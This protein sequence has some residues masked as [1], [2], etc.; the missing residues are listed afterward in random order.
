[1]NTLARL[2]L[3][4][5][6]SVFI[7]TVRGTKIAYNLSRSEVPGIYRH[8]NFFCGKYLKELIWILEKKIDLIISFKFIVLCT[9]K[10]TAYS[11]S[12]FH[13]LTF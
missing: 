4:S 2:C 8:L 6:A 10:G 1:M 5:L 3:N 13:H 9:L 7:N 12:G 11:F